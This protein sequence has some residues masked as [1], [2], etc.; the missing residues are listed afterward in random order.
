MIV[1]FD[2]IVTN[3]TNEDVNITNKLKNLIFAEEITINQK[4]V[5]MYQTKNSAWF[6]ISSNNNT[7]IKLD[8]SSV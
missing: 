3:N 4:Y 5:N 7:P 6:F 1:S 8:D 2:E